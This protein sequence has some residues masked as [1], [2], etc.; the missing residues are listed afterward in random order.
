[1]KVLIVDDNRDITEL[2][3]DFM[4][5]SGFET[6]TAGNGLEAMDKLRQNRFDTVI[7]DGHMPYMSGFDLCRF[8]KSEY[9]SVYTIGIT[10]SAS[11]EKFREAGADE[12]FYKPVD[13]DMLCALI[14]KHGAL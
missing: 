6:A 8:I 1:M 4:D 3:A 2:L 10:D 14:E 5:L 9:P 11:L 13:C 12:Y 7:M